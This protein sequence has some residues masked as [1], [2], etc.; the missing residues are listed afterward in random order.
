ME[1]V[2]RLINAQ[3]SIS[4]TGTSLTADELCRLLNERLKK[5]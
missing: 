2:K 3:E 5:A 1:K 4:V